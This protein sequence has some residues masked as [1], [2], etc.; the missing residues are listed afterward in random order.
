MDDELAERF[1]AAAATCTRM[2]TSRRTRTPAEVLRALADAADAMGLDEWDTYAER[3]PV[4]RLEAEVAQ[5]LGKPAAAFFPSG[6]MAQQ[7]ALRVWTDRAGTRR[8]A[9]PDLSHLLV[10]ELDGP[11]L[12]H[13]LEI[14]HLTT[15]R[16]VATA[17]DLARVPGRLAAILVEL[18]LRDAGCLLPAWEELEALSAAAHERDIR[19]HF[20]GA[21]LWEAQPF[22]DRP[23][24]EISALAD[25]VYVSFY[26]GLDGLAGACLAGPSE[27]VDEARRWRR[28]MGGTV[29]RMTPEAIGA[30]AGLRDRLPS[31]GAYVA[32]ARSLAAALPVTVIPNPR[33]PHTNTFEL[34][35]A[36][37]ATAVNE[38]LLSFID[39]HR[40]LLSGPWRPTDEPG[41]IMTELAIGEPALDLDPDEVAG[42][43]GAL[44]AG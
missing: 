7:C 12:V 13:G 22:Y 33:V 23:L 9:M 25:S 35:A 10:H 19:V 42:W 43:L 20:D 18:P 39:E 16:H 30:L 36:G 11:R 2:V 31:M 27:F 40:L 41:R 26:K 29:Y 3:G 24:A 14:E 6:I 5:L 4:A 17:D 37:D 21:R 15:G 38:R 28:R 32:W 8:V 1:R 34:F 44:I